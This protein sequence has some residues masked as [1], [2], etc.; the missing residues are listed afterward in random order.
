MKT[1]FKTTAKRVAVATVDAV[2]CPLHM[3]LQ[4]TSNIVQL[5]ADSVA[6]GEGYIVEK[7]DNT[8]DREIVA[9]NRVDYTQHQF[10][11]TALAIEALKNKAQ[12]A[13]EAG[14]DKITELTAKPEPQQP[15]LV[16][17]KGWRIKEIKPQQA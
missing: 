15:E 17:P 6:M 12:S 16:A 8:Q 5:G 4:L 13:Y 2:A 9:N 11:Q 7:I 3:A 1:S 14:K 10:M